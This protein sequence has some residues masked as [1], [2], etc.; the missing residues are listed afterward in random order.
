MGQGQWIYF[1]HRADQPTSY[2]GTGC[3][4]AFWWCRSR[5]QV[6]FSQLDLRQISPEMR[7]VPIEDALAFNLERQLQLFLRAV[8][9]SVDPLIARLHASSLSDALP[10]LSTILKNPKYTLLVLQNFRPILLDLCARWLDDEIDDEEKFSAFGF[11]IP[12]CE[13]LYPYVSIP[14]INDTNCS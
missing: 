6:T 2:R 1:S 5:S 14:V 9:P 12:C 7:G 13:E 8:L 11:L 3:D 4:F 10:L